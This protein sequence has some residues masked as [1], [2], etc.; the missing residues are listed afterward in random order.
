MT[1]NM[2]LRDRRVPAAVAANDVRA[3]WDAIGLNLY[4]M[5]GS[6]LSITRPLPLAIVGL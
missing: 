1:T 6:L 5:H 2:R 3:T 4:Y